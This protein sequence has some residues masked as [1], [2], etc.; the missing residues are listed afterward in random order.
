MTSK[1]G[2]QLR[3]D[4]HANYNM[5]Y[6]T[7]NNTNP[8]SIYVSISSW[9]KPIIDDEVNY[10][11]VITKL[12][13]K[14]KKHLFDNLEPELFDVKRSIVIFDMR[15]S[16]IRFNKKSYMNCEITLYQKKLFKLG[17]E[18]LQNNLNKLSD[19]L[20]KDIL[21]KSKYFKFFKT[22]K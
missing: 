19:T 3:I 10:K 13:K 20:I 15:E 16:G 9:A 17:D 6:G 14:L 11:N 12:Q 5:I 22:K 4:N 18:T 7:V 21:K 1:K 8:K 2:K